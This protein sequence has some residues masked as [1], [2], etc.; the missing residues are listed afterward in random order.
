MPWVGVAAGGPYFRTDDGRDWTP[1]GQNDA[2]DWPD[3]S[4][5]FR[6]RD[7][8]AVDAHLEHLR[9]QGVT[10]L[11]LMLEYAQGR[12]RYLERPAGQF[13]PNMVRF[14][15]DLFRLCER[16][17]LRILLTPFD[18]FWMWLRWPRHPYNRVNGGHLRH[19]SELLSC[20]ATRHAIKARMTFAVERWGGSGALFAWDLLNE[21]HPAHDGGCATNFGA[22]IH[23][24]STHVRQLEERLY[25]RSHLQTI[26]VFGPELGTAA[27]ADIAEAVFR[28]PDLDFATIHLY[29][30]GTIDYPRD[31]VVPALATGRI[32]QESLSEI[33]DTRPFLDT[34]HGPIHAFKDHRL[35]LPERFDD[36]YFR[37][38]Q[39]AHLAAGGAG[40]GMRWPNRH[41]HVLTAGMRRAQKSLSDFAALVDWQRFR[42]STAALCIDSPAVAGFGCADSTQMIG[43][44]VRRDSVRPDGIL[45]AAAAPL[46]ASISVRGLQPGRYRATFWNTASG[47]IETA[48]DVVCDGES[49]QVQFAIHTDLAVLLRHSATQL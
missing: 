2:V 17:G 41:P 35:T 15:D 40:G 24:I 44:F 18:T 1:I 5:L 14:W 33:R 30:T 38:M 13:V 3:L 27:G 42:R 4:G 32:V 34:E 25:G 29:E 31:T 26:S 16:H 6:R 46:T 47:S 43:W 7:I 12:H 36:E 48:G 21:I 23:D 39:W 9:A 10:C 28:H 20:A 8:A 11:R 49:L 37:H 45:D 19:P 22:F